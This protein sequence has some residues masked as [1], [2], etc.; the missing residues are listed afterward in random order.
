M[1]NVNSTRSPKPQ[2]VLQPQAEHL[3][4]A[5]EKESIA[6]CAARYGVTVAMHKALPEVAHGFTHFLLAIEPVRVTVKKPDLRAAS[7]GVMW[8]S[9][10]DAQGAALPAPVRRIL[11]A[12][13]S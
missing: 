2:A 13:G 12:L 7:P 5:S 4:E 6:A 1:S 10:E 9:L 8:L 3:P 11:T